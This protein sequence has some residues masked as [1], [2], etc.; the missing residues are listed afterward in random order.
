M[1]YMR[2]CKAPSIGI[3]VVLQMKDNVRHFFLIKITMWII[4]IEELKFKN[5]HRMSSTTSELWAFGNEWDASHNHLHQMVTITSATN[6]TPTSIVKI[7]FPFSYK[8]HKL[9][10]KIKELWR[11]KWSMKFYIEINDWNFEVMKECDT[12]PQT[13]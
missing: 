3:V 13:L 10:N 2:V 6:G 8:N 9:N 4:R 7:H 12:P 1:L 11:N 5:S